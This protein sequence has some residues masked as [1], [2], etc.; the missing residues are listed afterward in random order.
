MSRLVLSIVMVAVLAGGAFANIPNPALSTVPPVILVPNNPNTLSSPFGPNILGYTVNVQGNLGPVIGAVV[1]LRFSPDAWALI[2]K[3]D[4]ADGNPEFCDTSAA[5][6]P[7]TDYIC[8][9]TA[10]NAGDATFNISGGG[11]ILG[12]AVD[13]YTVEVWANG[14][15]L[16]SNL[17]IFSPDVTNGAGQTTAI[18]GVSNCD[19]DETTVGLADVVFHTGDFAGLVFNECSDFDDDGTPNLADALIGTQYIVNGNTCSCTP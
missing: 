9:A 2:A 10:D 16:A 1:E 13:P 6:P 14:V 7:A 5:V 11:C 18:S 3:C 19:V 15:P 8:V 4:G 12:G 17:K